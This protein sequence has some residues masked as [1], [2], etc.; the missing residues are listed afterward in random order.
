M[1]NTYTMLFEGFKTIIQ[2]RAEEI[3]DLQATYYITKAAEETINE[4]DEEIKRKV[5]S[6]NEYYITDEL[7][8][9]MTKRGINPDCDDS[10]RVLFPV[11][12]DADIDLTMKKE[13]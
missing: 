5:L 4:I 13:E 9:L 1:D 10:E 12:G 11:N 6:E 3:T 2:E 7:W 8:E